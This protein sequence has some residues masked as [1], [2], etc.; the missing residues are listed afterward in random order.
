[1]FELF[2]SDEPTCLSCF[3]PISVGTYFFEW[4]FKE[5][6]LCTKCRFQMLPKWVKHRK[7]G[8]DIESIYRYEGLARSLILNFKDSEDKWLRQAFLNPCYLKF[9][10]KYWGYVIVLAPSSQENRSYRPNKE[11]VKDLKLE[12]IDDVFVKLKSYKQSEMSL[13]Q[14]ADVKDVI[15]LKNV[16]QI[17]NKKVLI[18]DDICTTG[19]TLKACHDLISCE[20][21]QIRLFTLFYH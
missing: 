14:R 11:L 2:R 15:A 10:L 3:E 17:R 8:L 1:M 16:H 6:G 21:S 20:V 12:V 19:N 9:H 13:K 7:L 18:F 5:D 4:W